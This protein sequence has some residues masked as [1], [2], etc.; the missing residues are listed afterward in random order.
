MGT[1]RSR[2]VA[3]QRA[4]GSPGVTGA[5]SQGTGQTASSE[6]VLGAKRDRLSS[7]LGSEPQAST[8]RMSTKGSAGVPPKLSHSPSGRVRS[9]LLPGSFRNGLCKSRSAGRP[10]NQALCPLP[11]SPSPG[12]R[13]GHVFNRALANA[14]SDS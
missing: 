9:R 1:A 5:S 14:S 3:C 13:C 4:R 2:P 10:R 12:G 11:R 6:C 7:R 8:A